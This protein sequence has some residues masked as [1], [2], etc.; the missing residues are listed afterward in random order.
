MTDHSPVLLLWMAMLAVLFGITGSSHGQQAPSD[1]TG[2]PLRPGM[3]WQIEELEGDHRIVWDWRAGRPKLVD[4]ATEKPPE[5]KRL[6]EENRIGRSFRERTY[7]PLEGAPQRTILDGQLMLFLREIDQKFSV[8][9]QDAEAG[10]SFNHQILEGFE[11][12]AGRW[13]AGTIEIEG[14]PCRIYRAPWPVPPVGRDDDRPMGETDPAVVA[15][16]AVEDGFPRRLEVPGRILRIIPLPVLNPVPELPVK[17]RLALE[18]DQKK[19]KSVRDR[20][21]IN[22]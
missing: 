18:D 19:A 2:I 17:A 22:Q 13:L 14:T 21:R 20:Y 11:W 10:E 6:V 4:A 12:V 1:S 7:Y 3:Q 5:K 9:A 8:N 15:A 16:I